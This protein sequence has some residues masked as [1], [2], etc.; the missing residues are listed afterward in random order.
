[1]NKPPT[2]PLKIPPVLKKEKIGKRYN[3]CILAGAYGFLHL[4]EFIVRVDLLCICW[5]AGSF[6][7]SSETGWIEV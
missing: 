5:I 6:T 4:M 7:E 1:M 3:R 2:F